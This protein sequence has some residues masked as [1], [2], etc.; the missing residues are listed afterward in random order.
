[1]TD[2][3]Q[4]GAAVGA[5]QADNPRTQRLK[6]A[7]KANIARRKDQARARASGQTGPDQAQATDDT[8][9]E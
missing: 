4:P 7:L 9:H 5:S 6:A 8:N 2:N 1:M 3:P